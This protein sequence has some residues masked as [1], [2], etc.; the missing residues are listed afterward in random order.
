MSRDGCVALPRDAMVCL[1]FVRVLFPDHTH[2]LFSC[3][4][5]RNDIFKEDNNQNKPPTCIIMQIFL[6]K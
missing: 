2:L 5:N 4:G 1:R 3:C 6:S